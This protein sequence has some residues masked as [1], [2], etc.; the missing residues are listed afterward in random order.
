MAVQDIITLYHSSS[1]SPIETEDGNVEY[2]SLILDGTAILTFQYL[3]KRVIY[4]FND[5]GYFGRVVD[6]RN[7]RKKIQDQKPMPDELT[8]RVI[9]FIQQKKG[10]LDRFNSAMG[11]S[12][13]GSEH[14][15]EDFIAE[16]IGSSEF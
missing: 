1:Q 11:R 6:K 12:K 15:V 10:L 3:N 2:I 8:A 7:E 16:K 13:K 9:E 14:T 5:G 4:E